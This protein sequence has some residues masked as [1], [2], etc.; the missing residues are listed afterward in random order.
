MNRQDASRH[1][2]MVRSEAERRGWKVKCKEKELGVTGIPCFIAP[3][4]VGN[5][6][7]WV[8]TK[9]NSNT[10]HMSNDWQRNL[11]EHV[12]DIRGIPDWL[13][14]RTGEKFTTGVVRQPPNGHCLSIKPH[15]GRSYKDAWEALTKYISV[16]HSVFLSNP[17]VIENPSSRPFK[18]DIPGD[19]VP[20]AV[21][22]RNLLAQECVAVI[23]LG[24]VG[25]WIADFAIKTEAREVHG[26]D[27]DFIEGKSVLRMPGAVNPDTWIGK[28]KAHWFEET[29]SLIR[30]GVHGHNERVS[31]DNVQHAIGGTT[32]AFVAVD[33]DKDRMMICDALHG[34]SIPFVVAG[35]SLHHEDKRVKVGMRIVT[36]YPNAS[37]WRNVI[38]QVGK[39]GQDDY[40][41]IDIPDVY[42]LAA[43]W[44]V[45]SW[46]K[47]R[48]QVWQDA[49]E[50]CLHYYADRQRVITQGPE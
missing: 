19:H 43:G 24:G 16:V 50:E 46:R 33:C 12:A 36:A 40:G 23:G 13:Y 3:G 25:A 29:Y 8:G 1:E 37:S 2:L 39:A 14:Y 17:T 41:S 27:H 9:P 5:C 7:I 49:R 35:L 44:A 30:H 10:L 32:F 45:Q 48:G 34:A 6:E 20:K 22:W 26:W 18:F 21:E 47:M 11:A 42:S 15:L 31:I 28:P 38:P 4:V